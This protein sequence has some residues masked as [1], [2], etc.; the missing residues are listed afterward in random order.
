MAHLKAMAARQH[1]VE[2]KHNELLMG[3]HSQYSLKL[4]HDLARAD[5]PSRPSL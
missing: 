2:Q 5:R 1:Q 3:I 4:S